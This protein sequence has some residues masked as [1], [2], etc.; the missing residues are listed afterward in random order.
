MAPR[1]LQLPPIPI[2]H[3]RGAK[4]HK[5]QSVA[6]W[7]SAFCLVFLPFTPRPTRQ[8]R[9][10]PI[11]LRSIPRTASY[12]LHHAQWRGATTK[13]TRQKS[14]HVLSF[15]PRRTPRC[16][17]AVST[18]FLI[19]NCLS[20]APY[21]GATTSH[22]GEFPQLSLIICVP[23]GAQ[24]CR[25]E[26]RLFIIPALAARHRTL[27]LS[28]FLTFNCSTEW[29]FCGGFFK[30]KK[31]FCFSHAPAESCALGSLFPYPPWANPMPPPWRKARPSSRRTPRRRA[32]GAEAPAHGRHGDHFQ[33]KKS[34]AG[35]VARGF[36]R[37]Y[38]TVFRFFG[39][40]AFPLPSFIRR[41]AK[42]EV[43]RALLF[44]LSAHLLLTNTNACSIIICKHI[45]VFLRGR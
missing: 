10:Q 38:R 44:C 14:V 7:R 18:P 34:G 37:F 9:E 5:K 21:S 29:F 45:F 30:A 40:T 19:Y 42:K 28:S 24:P 36:L 2:R 25:Q 32:P 31:V 16:N 13:G 23:E 20:F 11:A 8:G 43:R 3:G 41:S 12:H 6:S 22:M 4:K 17:A 39:A 1:R 35:E 27:F 33:I 15:P 26:L